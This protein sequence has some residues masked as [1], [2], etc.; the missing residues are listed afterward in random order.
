MPKRKF[1]NWDLQ[2]WQIGGRIREITNWQVFMGIDQLQ[3]KIDGLLTRQDRVVIAIDGPCGAGKTTLAA[4]LAQRYA[5]NVI[6]MD[7]FVLRPQQRTPARFAEPGGNVDYERFYEEVLTPLGTGKAFSYRPFDCK[8]FTLGE[9][10]L[11]EPKPLCIVEGSYSLHPYFGS[12]YDLKV[13]LTVDPQ[14]QRER[15]LQRP[16]ALHKRFFEQWIPMEH[17]YLE[18]C[19][20]AEQVD[21]VL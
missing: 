9:P 7:A 19:N 13:L 6:H 3:E 1:V 18:A 4:K 14:V 21:L 20:I 17:C 10:V 15:I 12:P 2:D 11:V 8:T 5:C 16:A